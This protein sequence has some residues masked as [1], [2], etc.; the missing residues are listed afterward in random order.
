MLDRDRC[1]PGR[2]PGKTGEKRGWSNL[3]RFSGGSSQT[4]GPGM[5]RSEG[6]LTKAQTRLCRGIVPPERL[7]TDLVVT[8][9]DG[10]K[11]EWRL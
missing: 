11:K 5:S 3:V 6:S 1:R 10:P 2:A 7:G 8:T 4:W 9:G